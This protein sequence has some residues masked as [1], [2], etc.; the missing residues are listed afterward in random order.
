MQERISE[1]AE[2]GAM[3]E[4]GSKRLEQDYDVKPHHTVHP[5][6]AIG[7]LKQV[8]SFEWDTDKVDGRLFCMF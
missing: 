4:S 5:G 1:N 2:E 7:F 3:P 8:N 6:N